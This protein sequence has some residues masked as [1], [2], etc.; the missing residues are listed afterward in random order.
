MRRVCVTMSFL[1]VWVGINGTRAVGEEKPYYSEKMVFA[2]NER[3][4]SS[5]GSTVLELENGELLCAWYS[6]SRE[7]GNDVAILG[8]RLARGT[9]T[10]SEP[11]VWADAP[12]KSE[13]NP[14]LYLG[15]DGKV[16]LF[17]Q[18]MYG[19]GKGRT[20]QGTGWTTCKI[21]A[22]T[23][24]DAGRTWSTE[25]ILVD[26]LGYLT[27]NKAVRLDNGDILLPAQD[28]RNWSSRILISKD[29]GKSWRFSQRIDCGGG[30]HKGNIEPAL[31]VRRD[32]SLLCYMRTGADRHRVWESVSTDGGWHWSKP[33]E[34]AVPNPNSALDLL[35]LKSGTVVMALNPI[36]A[37]RDQLS[38]VISDDDAKTWKV[39]RDVEKAE[40]EYSYPAI[41]QTSDG[42]IQVTYSYHRAGIKHVTVN[43][44]WIRAG[45]PWEELEWVR[46]EEGRR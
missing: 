43:E 40:G 27:R 31:L 44:A 13:G 19:S 16:W 30:F 36:R 41:I 1:A 23:T 7:K 45:R 38:L 25:R 37:N 10:W 26:E 11:S 17:Y 12:G 9:K 2:G 32:G 21:K 39:Y 15:E 35:R 22:K 14:V 4:P 29:D 28:E 6:G 8:A 42:R 3:Y 24:G 34:I 5:H 18:T 20:R 33:T 46:T